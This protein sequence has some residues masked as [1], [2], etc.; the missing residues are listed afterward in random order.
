MYIYT[1]ELSKYR[2]NHYRNILWPYWEI[3]F[4]KT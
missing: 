3:L 1:E 2:Q 4:D